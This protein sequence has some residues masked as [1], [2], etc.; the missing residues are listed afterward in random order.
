[1]M[2]G[3]D[4]EREN[5]FVIIVLDDIGVADILHFP[6]PDGNIIDW[7]ADCRIAAGYPKC[8]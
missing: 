1:M 7:G 8:F 3:G 4:A 5:V 6:P 2:R